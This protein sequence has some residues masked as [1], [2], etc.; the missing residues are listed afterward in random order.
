M[1]P[2][3]S[4]IPCERLRRQRLI[5]VEYKDTIE[6]MRRSTFFGL[7]V[8]VLLLGS[9]APASAANQWPATPV[10]GAAVAARNDSWVVQANGVVST[11]R[12]DFFGDARDTSLAQPITG[13]AVNPSGT[14]YW[15]VAADGGVFA[16]GDARF[17]GSMGGT[18]LNQPIVG[19]ASSGDGRGYWLVAADGGMF[20][21]GDAPFLGSLG[22]L[23]LVQPIVGIAALTSGKGYRLVARDGGVFAFGQAAFRGSLGGTGI[24]DVIGI[25]QTPTGN[26]YWLLRTGGRTYSCAVLHGGCPGG[27]PEGSVAGPSV[28]HFGDARSLQP[29]FVIV[30]NGPPADDFDFVGNPIVAIVANPVAQGYVILRTK[31]DSLGYAGTVV[32]H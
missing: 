9:A 32:R 29:T 7:V 27:I 18:H 22:A 30:N 8:T 31:A 12:A 28:S 23:H 3:L 5:C 6:R 15:L 1:I 4:A 2:V 19:I 26:G 17:Y 13:I 25:A 20:A 10:A 24:T 14:G 11:G 16:Y 21:F